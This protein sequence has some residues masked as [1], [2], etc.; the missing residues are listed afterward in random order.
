MD[1]VDVF[2]TL[3]WIV[4]Q[5]G[6]PVH[7]NRGVKKAVPVCLQS[8]EGFQIRV[9]PVVEY[10]VDVCRIDTVFWQVI[11][12]ARVKCF[13]SLVLR[14]I[15]RREFVTT[16]AVDRL[17]LFSFRKAFVHNKARV[18]GTAT[19]WKFEVQI[20]SDRVAQFIIDQRTVF[21]INAWKNPEPAH[22]GVDFAH[23]HAGIF[24]ERWAAGVREM[25][26]KR[27]AFRLRC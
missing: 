1:Q 18:D 21:F 4:P 13:D 20:V 27:A 8:I 17:I 9:P 24:R 12:H 6:V 15:I 3:S 7:Q 5:L 26:S 14:L 19:Y 22:S 2:G 10:D 11:Q 16:H 23:G 25:V